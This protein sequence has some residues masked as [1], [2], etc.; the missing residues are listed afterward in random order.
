[1]DFFGHQEKARRASGRLVLLFGLAVA[2][3][4]LCI[5]AAAMG[6]LL[7]VHLGI[8]LGLFLSFPYG[9]FVHGL[10]R[11]AALVKYAGERRAGAFI[12]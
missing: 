10:Y 5:Y 3:M 12:D 1:M 8:V 4:I 7:A 2:G 9:K 6:L 11:L